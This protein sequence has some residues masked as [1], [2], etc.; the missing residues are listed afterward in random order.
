MHRGSSWTDEKACGIYCTKKSWRSHHWKK[1]S[2]QK[3]ATTKSINL[4]R[5]FVRWKLLSPK[6][7]WTKNGKS[8]KSCQRGKWTRWRTKKSHSWRIH[9]GKKRPL[10]FI[11]GHLSSQECGVK[12]K[13]PEMVKDD[14]SP[15]AVFTEQRSSASQMTATQIMHII[16]RL[17]DCA[18]QAADAVSA[19]TQVK[20]EDAPKLLK[21]IPKSECPDIWIRLPK[22]KWQKSWYSMEDPV[23]PLERNLYGNP[24]A[25]LMGKAIWESSTRTRLGKVFNWESL[26]VNREK[27]LFLSVYVDDVKL[28]SKT[29]NIEPTW[30]I[31]ME[32]VELGEP[33]SFLDHVYLGC[34]QRVWNQQGYSKQI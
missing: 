30:Q 14:S 24:W 19:Y 32:D 8:S 2:I 5:C 13:A 33:T 23:V 6:P 15:Y 29:G 28:A 18:G 25:G 16:S 9:R 7:Q 21:K 3:A 34:T 20:M 11:D 22:H 17:R 4:F 12:T 26:F 10:C 27:G 31:L 1:G